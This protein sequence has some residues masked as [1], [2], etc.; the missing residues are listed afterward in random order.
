MHVLDNPAWHALTG[1]Q[2]SL[3]IGPADAKRFRPD[4]S[5]FAA[6]ADPDG[7]LD[8]LAGLI[9]PAASDADADDALGVFGASTGPDGWETL[10]VYDC[11]QLTYEHDT[12]PELR[13]LG[14]DAVLVELGDADVPDALDLVDRTRPGPFL[15]R[16]I[17]FGGYRGIRVGG[18]LAAMAGQRMRPDGWCEVS[19]VCV[20]PDFRGRGF[21]ATAMVEV[22]R[23]IIARGERPFLHVETT[24]ERA[25]SVY[26]AL[27]FERRRR[28]SILVCR[29]R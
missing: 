8:A 27:G 25:T 3:A 4:V 2:R 5:P 9:L 21:A 14:D 22:M 7:P 11:W 19:A 12:V 29:P 26:E 16:T 1:A 24:N 20:D 15:P 17:E 23:G 10:G 18:R 13:P 6:V 28:A